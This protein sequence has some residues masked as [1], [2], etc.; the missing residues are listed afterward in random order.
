MNYWKKIKQS[1]T[2]STSG[3]L[4][5]FLNQINS[6]SKVLEIGCGSG[7]IIDEC[8]SRKSFVYG[9]DINKNEIDALRLKYRGYEKVILEIN[10][11]TNKNFKLK[12]DYKFDYVFINGLLGA[13]KSKQRAV[14]LKNIL[15]VT[16]FISIVHLSEFLLFEENEEMK[17]RYSKDFLETG[18]YGTFFVYNVEGNKVYQTHNFSEIEITKLV[19][20]DFKVV[21]KELLNFK[22]YT[23]KTK[24]GIILLL[25]KK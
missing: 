24:P 8:I 20:K 11:I 5:D 23:N 3:I 9:V 16:D 7:R 22:S 21:R 4:D 14:A 10:D 13:L 19:S 25:Q 15:K 12:E 2:P 18:E 1:N 6:Q 17:V